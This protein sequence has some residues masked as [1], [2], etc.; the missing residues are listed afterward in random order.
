MSASRPCGAA[1]LLV[2][3]AL[4]TAFAPAP[5]QAQT[6][7]GIKAGVAL[8][9]MRGSAVGNVNLRYGLT[10]GAFLDI[11]VTPSLFITPQVLYAQKGARET[12]SFSLGGTTTLASGTWEYDYADFDVLVKRKF[13]VRRTTFDLYAG[14]QYALLLSAKAVGAGGHVDLKK[15]TKSG[16]IGGMIG[17]SIE[18]DR[19]FLFDLSY[20]FGTVTID[21]PP[22]SSIYSR[23]QNVISAMVGVRLGT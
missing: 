14:P 8:A 23:T 7:L 15:Y 17:G 6:S 9:D 13:G 1:V 21:K 19:R 3:A 2:I 11:P 12:E 16:D 5:V 22:L 18:F 20:S 10:G 4:V